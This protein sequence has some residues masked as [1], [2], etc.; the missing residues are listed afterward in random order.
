MIEGVLYLPLNQTAPPPTHP[1]MMSSHLYPQR[2]VK[3]FQVS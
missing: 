1:L 2:G 3:N